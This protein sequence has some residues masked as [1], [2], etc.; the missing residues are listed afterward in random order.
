MCVQDVIL[1][2]LINLVSHPRFSHS[3]L[4]CQSCHE[5]I[6]PPHLGFTAKLQSTSAFQGEWQKIKTHHFLQGKKEIFHLNFLCYSWC[7]ITVI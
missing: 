4:W 7:N 2:K 6:C 1:E 5:N 3:E